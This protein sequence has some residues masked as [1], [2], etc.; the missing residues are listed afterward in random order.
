MCQ[1]DDLARTTAELARQAKEVHGAI[2]A[3]GG[4]GTI[5]TVAQAAH[6]AGC[7]M[8]VIPRGTFNYFGRTHGIATE[9][10]AA[11][12][13]LLAG[14]PE[15]V[16]VAAVN[17]QL[18]LV[19]ASVGLYPDLLED[20]EVWKNR[21]GRSRWVAFFA[22]LATVMRSQ[23]RLTLRIGVGEEQ[24]V[25]RTLTLFVGNNRLQLEQV[26]MVDGP[27]SIVVRDNGRVMAVVLKPIGSF[28]M[29]RLLLRGAMGTL[30]EADSIENFEFEK[31]VV[32]PSRMMGRRRIKMAF[33]GEVVHMQ[34]PL[35]FSVMAKPL[36]LLKPPPEE[37]E[38]PA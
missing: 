12:A 29:L 8:G 13:Q 31:M 5:N 4:D 23:Q 28:A 37:R 34:P 21:Y 2:V 25:V 18:F 30:G 6:T 9:V 36:Y 10:P 27:R 33:D 20:R 15:P 24:R 7:A 32:K 1:P 26:G 19:N 14:R 17:E 38:V 35:A 22:A 11:M 16:Q 3:V